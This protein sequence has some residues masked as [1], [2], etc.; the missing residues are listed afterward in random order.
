MSARSSTDSVLTSRAQDLRL[1]IIRDP[2]MCGDWMNRYCENADTHESLYYCDV[3]T[4][5]NL[6]EF[7][8]GNKYGPVIARTSRCV[9]TPGAT[10][11]VTGKNGHIHYDERR[12]RSSFSEGGQHYSWN[13]DMELTNDQG[14]VLAQMSFVQ[15]Q[16]A[17]RSGE[18]VIKEEA[19]AL[20]EP[21][22]L[23]ALLVQERF[24]ESKAY[25]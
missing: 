22:V 6:L 14:S 8:R 15:D 23:S 18:L 7:H 9:S 19:I 2:G 17:R 10:D 13:S 16:E 4:D 25:F 24:D 20:R 11:I 21:I 12:A 3:A 1:D 5:E